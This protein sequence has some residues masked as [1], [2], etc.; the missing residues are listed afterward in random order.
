MYGAPAGLCAWACEHRQRF[1]A[2]ATAIVINQKRID[3]FMPPA[4]DTSSKRF[5]RLFQC[6]PILAAMSTHLA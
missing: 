6:R 1:A 4:P 5:A 3:L 2:I